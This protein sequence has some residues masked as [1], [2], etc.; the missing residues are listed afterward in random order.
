MRCDLGT[1]LLTLEVNYKKTTEIGLT[2][3]LVSLGKE[4]QQFIIIKGAVTINNHIN[5]LEY[6]KSKLLG[7]DLRS[8]LQAIRKQD[9]QDS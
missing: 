7:Y 5:F 6:S 4:K 9:Q 3:L 2:P 8:T 1:L